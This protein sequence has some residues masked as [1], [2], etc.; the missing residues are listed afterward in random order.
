MRLMRFELEKVWRRRS[1]LLLTVLLLAVN[2]FFLWYLNLPE[3][4]IPPLTAYGD[5][6]QELAGKTEA[7]KQIFLQERWEKMEKCTFQEQALF[8]EA[9]EEMKKIKDYDTF[10]QS[11]SEQKNTMSSISV[12]RRETADF[13]LRNG[14]K[15][16]ADY[17]AMAETRPQVML[18][19]SVRSALELPVTDLLL[20]LSIFFFAGASFFEEKRK[21][22]FFIIC[23]SRRGKGA[24]MAAKLGALA[25]HCISMTFLLCGS[26]LACT[27][28][29]AGLPA[30]TAPMQSL[31]PYMESTLHLS[32]GGFLV[33]NIL[34]KAGVLFAFGTLLILA[35]AGCRQNMIT[36][37]IGSA[38]LA[39]SMALYF[40]IP[41]NSFLNWLKYL[42]FYGSLRA[43]DLLGGYL[44]LDFLGYPVSRLLAV[45]LFMAATAVFMGTVSLWLFLRG[46]HLAAEQTKSILRVTQRCGKN[47]LPHGSLLRHEGW[48]CL[49]L[50]RAALILLAFVLLAGC[51][52]LSQSYILT[53]A[54]D[55]Y[56]SAMTN[57]EGPLTEEKE[58]WF[59]QE[60][61][62]FDKAFRQIR[63]IEEL[64]ADGKLTNAAANAMAEPYMKETAFYPVFQRMQ[65][66]YRW[67]KGAEDRVFVYDT[68]YLMALGLGGDDGLADYLL[69]TAA[70]ILSFNGF[71]AMEHQK[72]T[73]PLLASTELGER[74]IRRAKVKISLA[75]VAVISLAVFGFRLIQTAGSFPLH[76]LWAGTDS[77][78]PYRELDI[79]IPLVFWLAAA[80]LIQVLAVW[81]QTIITLFFSDRMKGQL[82]AICLATLVLLLPPALCAMGLTVTGWWGL[83]PL[84]QIGKLAAEFPGRAAA[85]LAA[86][87]AVFVLLRRK[88]LQGQE[89]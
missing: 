74:S 19:K 49:I 48:K 20:Y 83:Q 59:M 11:V 71:F 81:V 80:A 4:D 21:K 46:R 43:E 38:A 32:V 85:Y 24:T 65:R 1:F 77:L 68:G 22:L 39:V 33:C 67:V 5:L 51:R 27:F 50:Q 14:E 45:C 41:A 53:P 23:P 66:Q 57:L 16:A 40:L 8:S 7:E 60:Q 62:R 52:H 89:L 63:H 44:N 69:L 12:F 88:V 13:S 29:A 30:L 61:K 86:A 76:Q 70:V 42:N 35:A 87:A 2:L 78:E 64:Q 17:R 3:E 73:W 55:Y 28:A 15:E 18:S 37:V 75:A 58:K 82:P 84:Y 72:G 47:V 36:V 25:V 56:Q 54:E 9:Y 10:L 26:S 6:Q 79:G 34:L 31:A